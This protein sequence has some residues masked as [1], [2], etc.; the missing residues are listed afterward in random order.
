MDAFN[1]EIMLV[2]LQDIRKK[3]ETIEMKNKERFQTYLIE[4]IV[5]YR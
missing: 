1:V 3:G 2:K 5:F 4:T